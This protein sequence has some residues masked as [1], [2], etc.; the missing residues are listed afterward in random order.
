MEQMSAAL[1]EAMDQLEEKEQETA[2]KWF[3]AWT[4]RKQVEMAAQINTAKIDQMA[5]D[6]TFKAMGDV[7]ADEAHGLSMAQGQQQMQMATQ[8]PDGDEA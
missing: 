5:I 2:I 7:R 6:A 3:D 8:E 4:K 1:H